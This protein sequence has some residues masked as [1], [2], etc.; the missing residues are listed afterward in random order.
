MNTHQVIADRSEP[1]VLNVVTLTIRLTRGVLRPRVGDVF[2]N[3]FHG[4]PET[5][6]S[7]LETQLGLPSAVVPRASRVSEYGTLPHEVVGWVI[8]N[9]RFMDSAI[10][11]LT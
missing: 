7:W 6:L 1:I 3:E 11:I 5:L 10:P 2:V 8:R 4:G 9:K